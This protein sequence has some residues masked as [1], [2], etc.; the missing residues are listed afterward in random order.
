[1]LLRER[2][3]KPWEVDACDADFIDELVAE[4]AAHADHELFSIKDAD[5]ATFQRQTR[6]KVEILK[7]REAERDAD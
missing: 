2:G 7:W 3:L 1:M 6:R 5:A 4:L